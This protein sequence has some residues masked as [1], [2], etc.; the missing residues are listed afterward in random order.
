MSFARNPRVDLGGL[1]LGRRKTFG[2]VE[3]KA[4]PSATAPVDV[5]VKFYT[6]DRETM[7]T[8]G[9]GDKR[10]PY[11]Q[12]K[13]EFKRIVDWGQLKLMLMEMQFL[14]MYWNPNEI[15]N[16]IVLYI[17]A[18]SGKKG[19]MDF[20]AKLYPAVH[21]VLYDSEP[22]TTHGP[23]IEIHQKLFD[24]DDVK[25]WKP[26]GNRIFLISDIRRT[27]YSSD[28]QDYGSTEEIAENEKLVQEDMKLQENWVFE[29]NPVQAL[30]K[31]RLPYWYG[32]MMNQTLDQT[33][34]YLDGIVYLQPWI[35]AT[36]S[37]ARLVPTKFFAP[38]VATTPVVTWKYRRIDW[39]IK[40]YEDMIFYHNSEVREKFEFINPINNTTNR[41]FPE[42]GLNNEYDSVLSV[43]IVI[44]YLKKIG[45]TPT[46]ERVE[47]LM[48]QIMFECDPND[49]KLTLK[50]RQLQR[51]H[52]DNTIKL[53]RKILF[54]KELIKRLINLSQNNLV[55]EL[56]NIIDRYF[57]TLYNYPD[58]EPKH[59][60]KMIDELKEKK[61]VLDGKNID[62]NSVIVQ[63]TL[64]NPETV[65]LSN[66]DK[67]LYS[68]LEGILSAN[69]SAQL[70]LMPKTDTLAVTKKRNELNSKVPGCIF[71]YMSIGIGRGQHWGTNKDLMMYLYTKGFRNEAFASPFNS[72]M[73]RVINESKDA[74]VRS[75]PGRYFSLFSGDKY[76][77]SQG[78]FFESKM[79]SFSG[80]WVVNPPFVESIIEDCV[81]KILPEFENGTQIILITPSWTD[82]TWYSKLRSLTERTTNIQMITGNRMKY[83][84]YISEKDVIAPFQSVIWI[85]NFPVDNIAKLA[86]A[87]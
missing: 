61:I 70:E 42:L 45:V 32:K 39:N 34:S 87:A 31:F 30:L 58:D 80:G 78:N 7:T 49:S 5:P 66:D 20:L 1:T 62:N 68:K 64:L 59:I 15:P 46:D 19:H 13:G 36:S 17:G 57:L 3:T 29:I 9:T 28:V 50:T 82:T 54:R 12:R 23:N 74:S 76:F 44:D 21:F 4:T 14:N 77:R 2:A 33:F 40:T 81:N 11:R 73:E 84:D 69:I 27:A 6:F 51:E 60:Q 37:E 85:M 35:G 25:K 18:A 8:L 41:I 56:E 22:I 10:A 79:N 65:P 63:T 86:L 47:K 26:Y 43:Y 52:K 67:Q 83:Y 71:D 53:T 72:F 75:S 16:P 55:Y 24:D 38:T 48:E